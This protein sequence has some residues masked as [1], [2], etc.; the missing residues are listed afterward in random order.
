MLKQGENQPA[1]GACNALLLAVP[2]W[3]LAAL[4]LYLLFHR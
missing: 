3:L 2:V 1:L 4:T